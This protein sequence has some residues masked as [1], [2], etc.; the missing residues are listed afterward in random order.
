MDFVGAYRAEIYAPAPGK[1]VRAGRNGAYGL[2]VELDHGNGV[3]TRYGHLAKIL[4]KRSQ[5]LKRGD[6]LGLQG[7]T[8]RSTGAHLHYEIRYHNKPLNPYK[9]IKAGAYVL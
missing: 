2:F 1:V 3:T 7:N 5:L 8:G 9:F 6:A 4:V